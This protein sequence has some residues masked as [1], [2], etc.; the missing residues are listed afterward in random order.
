[1]IENKNSTHYYGLDGLGDFIFRE[2]IIAKI[3]RSKFAAVALLDL[4]KAHPGM[5]AEILT[6]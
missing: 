5:T 6:Y 4:V 2:E 3:D 1:M